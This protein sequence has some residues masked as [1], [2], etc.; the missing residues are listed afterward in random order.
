MLRRMIREFAKRLRQDQRKTSILKTSLMLI[1]ENG[2]ETVS[3]RQIAKEE[4]ISEVILYRYFR[5]KSKIL[6]EIFK[7]F[8]PIVTKSFQEFLESIKAMVTD[9][10]ISLPL[11]GKLYFNRIKEFP[12]FMM[13]ITKEGDKIPKY[14]LEVDK[15]IQEE[16]HYEPYRKILYEELKIHEVFNEYFI[17]CQKDGFLKKDLLPE[18]CTRTVLSIFLPLV[19]RSPLFPLDDVPSEEKF[20]EGIKKQIKIILYAFLPQEKQKLIK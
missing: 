5:N 7:H 20:E 12:F 17:R 19:I 3:M 9:L 10:T 11:I 8:V 18:D 14:L 13:F 6:E 4:G 1:A 2:Y 15:K 16:F